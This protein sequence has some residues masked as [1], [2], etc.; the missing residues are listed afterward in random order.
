MAELKSTILPQGAWSP[1]GPRSLEDSF[2]CWCLKPAANAYR[3]AHTEKRRE[4]PMDPY[5][6]EGTVLQGGRLGRHLRR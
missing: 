3:R 4:V 5:G 2:A 1:A 6:S